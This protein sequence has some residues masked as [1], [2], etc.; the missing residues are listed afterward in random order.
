MTIKPN[1]ARPAMHKPDHPPKLQSKSA[2]KH[3]GG[4]HR[5][6]DEHKDERLDKR[7]DDALELNPGKVE[8][9]PNFCS[10]RDEEAANIA[11]PESEAGGANY[12]S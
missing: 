11:R 8:I 2:T 5:A 6:P 12:G 9:N 4:K 3:R 10:G 7:L 1:A